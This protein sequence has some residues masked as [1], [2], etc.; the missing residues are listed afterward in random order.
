MLETE[1]IDPA[2]INVS[3][4]FLTSIVSASI[5]VS[6]VLYDP[7]EYASIGSVVLYPYL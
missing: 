7:V 1:Y 6:V 2:K 4:V 3:F 5:N